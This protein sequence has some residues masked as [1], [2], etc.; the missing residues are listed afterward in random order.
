[1]QEIKIT[2]CKNPKLWYKDRVGSTHPATIVNGT[3]LIN[4]NL[5]FKI[6]QPDYE[7]SS[8]IVT[9]SNIKYQN[10]IDL[11]E[12]SDLTISDVHDKMPEISYK[13]ITNIFVYLK[14]RG[15]IEK[16]GERRTNKVTGYNMSIYTISSPSDLPATVGGGYNQAEAEQWD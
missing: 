10:I 6:R 11:F 1:M 14:R 4:G 15:Y 5:L 8:E 13:K 2:S 12:N 9:E 3:A 7:I 16:T